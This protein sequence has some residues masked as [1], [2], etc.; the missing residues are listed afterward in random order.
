[1]QL[2]GSTITRQVTTVARS[3]TKDETVSESNVTQALQTR[4]PAI[5]ARVYAAEETRSVGAVQIALQGSKKDG[6]PEKRQSAISQL[7]TLC[8]TTWK[9]LINAVKF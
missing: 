7:R 2:F 8:A 9:V 1:L 4:G 6:P 5:I 3:E